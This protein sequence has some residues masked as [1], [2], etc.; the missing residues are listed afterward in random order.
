MALR[1]ALAGLNE[2]NF[3]IWV[4]TQQKSNFTFYLLDAKQY[5]GSDTHEEDYLYKKEVKNNNS[6]SLISA[7]KD[8]IKKQRE[9]FDSFAGKL[10]IVLV[11]AKPLDS[12]GKE[13][14]DNKE[15]LVKAIF[16]G[17]PLYRSLMEAAAELDATCRVPVWFIDK[18][19]RFKAVEA[20]IEA[21]D[22]TM[23]AK[24]WDEFMTHG[25]SPMKGRAGGGCGCHV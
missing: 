17:E 10:I 11:E 1:V 22:I 2:D 12:D 6:M 20:A 24:Y 4:T 14:T 5:T 18:F 7:T 23:A 16:Y 25:E 13:D 8:D 21:G 9:D 19:L 15:T 3:I